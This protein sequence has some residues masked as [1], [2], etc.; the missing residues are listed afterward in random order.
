MTITADGTAPDVAAQPE[1]FVAVWVEKDTQ[2]ILARLLDLDGE[3]RGPL[4]PVGFHAP[5]FPTGPPRVATDGAGDFVVVWTGVSAEAPEGAI[6]GRRFTAGGEPLDAP[7]LLSGAGLQRRFAPRVDRARDGRFVVA[8]SAR[9]PRTSPS[10]TDTFARWFGADGSPNGSSFRVNTTTEREQEVSDVA[11]DVAGEKALVVWTHNGGESLFTEVYAALV[12]PG[13]T[14]PE[15][16][17]NTD[18]E[19]QVTQQHGGRAVQVGGGDW[20]IVFHGFAQDGS[21]G[22]IVGR[23]FDRD[24][25]PLTGDVVL[26]ERTLGTQEEPAVAPLPGGVGFVVA[27]TDTCSFTRF[28]DPVA[29]MSSRDGSAAGIF[30]RAFAGDG[31]PLTPDFQVPLSSAEHQNHVALASNGL[32]VLA[33]WTDSTLGRVQAR[34]LVDTACP[35]EPE[36]TCLHG[37]RFRVEVEWTDFQGGSGDGTGTV[38][39]TDWASFWFFDPANVEL[40]VK[41]LDGRPVNGHWWVFFASLTNV[42]FTLHVTDLDRGLVRSYTNPPRTF[43]S[44]GDTLAFPDPGAAGAAAAGIASDA[45]PGTVRGGLLAIPAGAEAAAGP[46]EPSPTRLCLR[47]DEFAV[48]MTWLDFSG[49]SGIGRGEELSGD[50]GFFWF[51]RQGNPEVLVKVLD[52]RPVNGHYWVFFASLTNVEFELLVTHSVSG[53]AATYRNPLRHF[54]SRG[55]TLAF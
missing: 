25:A 39:G 23:L 36:A 32:A 9:I 15:V 28:C 29:G 17:V 3:P 44:R 7:V 21:G 37:G 22:S 43:A 20:W 47:D 2:R 18:A 55:D 31:T 53:N 54:A 13:A 51:F 1:G 48:E 5:D 49:N 24:L 10:R 26:N 4:I 27:W 40:G 35:G 6:Y 30:G 41:I 14:G 16:R 45:A 50:S 34:P 52:G 19:L 11:V 12:T 33:A 42:G 8:W 46:C 38:R